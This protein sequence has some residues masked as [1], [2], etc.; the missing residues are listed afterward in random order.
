MAQ[1]PHNIPQGLID[2][3]I[4]TAVEASAPKIR[5]ALEEAGEDQ[6]KIDAVIDRVA[7][8][9]FDTPICIQLP[10]HLLEVPSA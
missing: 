8:G 7:A 9:E 2:Q 5:A 4:N 6:D 10:D 1:L 3:A